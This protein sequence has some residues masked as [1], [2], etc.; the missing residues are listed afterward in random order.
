MAQSTL[1]PTEVT[2]GLARL[3][4]DWSA[5]SDALY[6]TV[7]FPAFRTAVEFISLLAPIADGMDHHPDI[8]L[9]WRTIELTLST[10]SAGGITVRDLELASRLDELIAQLTG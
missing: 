8:R 10:H 6:R 4:P 1:S 7:E 2:Q 5:D 3:S 9:S